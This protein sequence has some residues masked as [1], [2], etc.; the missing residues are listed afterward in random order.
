MFF[1]IVMVA[2]A[3]S[4]VNVDTDVTDNGAVTALTLVELLLLLF[5]IVC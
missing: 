5:F 1:G 2:T 3:G 4:T